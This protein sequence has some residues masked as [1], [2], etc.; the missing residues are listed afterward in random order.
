M[1]KGINLQIEEFKM[2][3]TSV[4]NQSHM[5]VSVVELVLQGLLTETNLIKQQQV[6][7]EKQEYES[8]L[9]AEKAENEESNEI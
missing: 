9:V 5:P 3:L 2:E 8:S 4:I 1:E 7:R 6:N